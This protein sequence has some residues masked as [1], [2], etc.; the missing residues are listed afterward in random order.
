ME[1]HND[2]RWCGS[3]KL[4]I[5]AKKKKR[6]KKKGKKRSSRHGAVVNKSD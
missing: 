6:K 1:F 5:L 3:F 2:M 4:K